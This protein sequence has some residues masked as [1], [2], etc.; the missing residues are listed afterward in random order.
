MILRPEARACRTRS[1]ISTVAEGCN[2]ATRVDGF[3]VVPTLF[4]LGSYL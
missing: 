4:M 1:V 3:G 2:D